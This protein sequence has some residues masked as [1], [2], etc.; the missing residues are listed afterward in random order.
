MNALLLRDP[1]DEKLR[2]L[3]TELEFKSLA[4]KI[5]KKPQQVQKPVNGQLDLFAEFTS[6]SPEV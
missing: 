2:A 3:F 1:D 6:E 5:L 4:Q